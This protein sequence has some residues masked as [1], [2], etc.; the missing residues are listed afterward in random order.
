MSL[1]FATVLQHTVANL[2]QPAHSRTDG[3]HFGFTF[4]PQPLAVHPDVRVETCRTDGGKIQFGPDN[5]I[6]PFGQPA[7]P[8]VLPRLPL[9]RHQ[10]DKGRHLRGACKIA[11]AV[12]RQHPRRNHVSYA[13]YAFEQTDVVFQI[14]MTVDMLVDFGFK[15]VNLF[16]QL[17][18]HRGNGLNHQCGR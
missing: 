2:N 14:G 17:R 12:Q 15:A 13:G 1:I 9:F 8:F 10:S 18:L 11:A 4:R 3:L 7:L 5:R 6:A 16:A